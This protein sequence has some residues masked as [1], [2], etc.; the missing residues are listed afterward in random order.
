M[1][2][3]LQSWHRAKCITTH[4]RTAIYIYIYIPNVARVLIHHTACGSTDFAI[5][6]NTHFVPCTCIWTAA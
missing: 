3:M 5:L 1:L 6:A 2:C 4:Q